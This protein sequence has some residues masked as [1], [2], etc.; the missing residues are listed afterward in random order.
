MPFTDEAGDVTE[1]L[2][3][4]GVAGQVE[5]QVVKRLG[6]TWA[7]L[8]SRAFVVGLSGN[9]GGHL[10]RG[11][12]HS[13]DASRASG[14]AYRAGRIGPIENHSGLYQALQVRCV[15]LWIA[16]VVVDPARPQIIGH[17]KDNIR[18]R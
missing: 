9:V 4:A 17:D 14:R 18:L 15:D 2:Q 8:R 1:F 10:D 5:R 6:V 3:L 11:R 13:G 12:R 16:I 7:A